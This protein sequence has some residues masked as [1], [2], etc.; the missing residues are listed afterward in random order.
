[1][2]APRAKPRS[3][4]RPKYAD[5]PAGMISSGGGMLGG[6]LGSAFGPAGTAVG[7]FL[8]GKIGHLI[9][10]ITGFGDYK[11]EEN[12]VLQG[13]MPVPEVVNTIDKG[14]IVIRHRE[15]IQDVQST[16]AFNALKFPLNPGQR[17]TFPWLAQIA[18]NFDQYRFRG[19]LFEFVSTSSDALLTSSVSTA[20][21]SVNM[22]TDYDVLDT[23][24]QSKRDMLN[25]EFSSSNKPSCTIIHP[26]ECKTSLSPMRLQYVRTSQVYPAGSD[27]RMYDLGNFFIATE[28]M[29]SGGGTIGELWVTYEIELYKQQ[30]GIITYA[31]HYTIINPLNTAWLLGNTISTNSNLG[32]S[33]NTA[34]TIYSFHPATSS[35]K[36]LVTYYLGSSAAAVAV[37][38]IALTYTNCQFIDN[39]VGAGATSFVQAPMAGTA[40]QYIC[41]QVIVQ[42]NSQNASITFGTSTIPVSPSVGDFVVTLLPI[43]YN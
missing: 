13:G 38:N 18:A 40:S 4:Y 29:Q 23:N 26:I 17:V 33:I 31:D 5:K 34:G 6:A 15:F 32:G 2:P 22:A 12:T 19:M 9:E 1:M 30:L 43:D 14:G 11:V 28:G 24:Y 10:K 35:G 36:F 27:G 42:V 41:S 37:G 20:L 21:G 16:I 3:N 8:G 7:S 39:W 25:S